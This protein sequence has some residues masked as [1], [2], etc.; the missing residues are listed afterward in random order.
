MRL[1]EV[2]QPPVRACTPTAALSTAAREMEAHNVG[3][4][5]VTD[6]DQGCA[7]TAPQ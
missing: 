5:V 1:R 2:M 4:L 7:P 3:S 6:E